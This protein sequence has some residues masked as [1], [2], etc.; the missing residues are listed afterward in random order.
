MEF[1]IAELLRGSRQRASLKRGELAQVLNVHPNTIGAC[2][3]GEYL[4]KTRKVV[5]RIG[6]E[7]HLQPAE[8]DLL[9]RA[10][11]FPDEY[12]TVEPKS[13]LHQLRARP[14]P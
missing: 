6:E 4:L 1:T 12:G 5:L 7:L 8:T 9:L 13:Y 2:E 3:R 10:A 11:S 14:E